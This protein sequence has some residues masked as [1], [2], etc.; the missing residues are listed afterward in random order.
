MTIP[1]VSY[2]GLTVWAIESATQPPL[3]LV[4][5]PTDWVDEKGRVTKGQTGVTGTLKDLFRRQSSPFRIQPI[6]GLA[7][8]KRKKLVK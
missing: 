7:T 4:C 8:K 1:V 2:F 5:H 6:R 3:D